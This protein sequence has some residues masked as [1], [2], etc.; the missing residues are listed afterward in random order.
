MLMRINCMDILRFPSRSFE[1]VNGTVERAPELVMARA[2]NGLA[3]SS[4]S[5]S[6]LL[7][8]A[9]SYFI[10]GMRSIR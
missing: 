1:L 2:K 8:S 10:F 7:S 6:T 5:S 3:A 4:S 9:R